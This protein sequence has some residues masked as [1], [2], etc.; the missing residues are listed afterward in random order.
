MKMNI[1]VD[2]GSMNMNERKKFMPANCGAFLFYLTSIKLLNV[3]TNRS[4]IEGNDLKRLVD[5]S[6]RN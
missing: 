3:T 1:A 6:E 5:N 2:V 4:N